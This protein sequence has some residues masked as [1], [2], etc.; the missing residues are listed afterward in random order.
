V[1]L[2]RR[3]PSR[4]P[5]CR[6]CLYDLCTAGRCARADVCA[7]ALG[8]AQAVRLLVVRNGGVRV[9]DDVMMTSRQV[10]PS[11]D[12]LATTAISR[13]LAYYLLLMID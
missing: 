5:D 11:A 13:Y 1:R 9:T 8:P 12:D 6:K 7:F 3:Q 10:P 4:L 2:A